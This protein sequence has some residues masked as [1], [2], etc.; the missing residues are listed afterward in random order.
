MAELKGHTS[1]VLFMAQ[2]LYF[3]FSFFYHN[4]CPCS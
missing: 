1:R 3:L 2:V 4:F